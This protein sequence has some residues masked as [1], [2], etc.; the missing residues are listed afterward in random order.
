MKG[1][2]P[3]I[4][5]AV[6]EYSDHVKDK[7]GFQSAWDDFS[8]INMHRDIGEEPR[9]MHYTLTSHVGN[10]FYSEPRKQFIKDVEKLLSHTIKT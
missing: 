3:K 10:D 1:S 5:N 8:G 7:Y 9:Y 6:I 2:H 4:S